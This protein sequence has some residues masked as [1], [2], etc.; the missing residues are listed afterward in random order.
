MAENEITREGGCLCGAVR[1][2][3]LGAPLWVAHCHCTSCRK[4]T[5]AAFA[6]YAGYRPE[7]VTW[8]GEAAR[9]HNSSPGVERGFCPHCGSSLFYAS[10]RWPDETHLLAGTF[11][12][13]EDLEPGAHVFVAER[14]PWVHLADGLPEFA[15]TSPEHEG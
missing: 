13:P 8:S 6:T 4:T 2:S 9:I 1:F 7:A 3:A 14:L 10:E 15:T 12:A 5:A 11:D